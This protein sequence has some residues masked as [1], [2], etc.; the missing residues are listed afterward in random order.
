MSLSLLAP[1]ALGL[2]LLV[3]LPLIAHIARQR[4]R[5]RVPFGA[6]LLLRRVIKRLRRRRRVK[7]PLLLILRI[8]LV[9]M[10]VLA[11]AG[12]RFS[13][14]GGAYDV[15]GT[16]RV[17]LLLDRS[18]SMS[19]QD[20]DSTLLSRARAAALSE[21]GSLPP[22]T[23]IGAVAFDDEAVSLTDGLVSD[24][25]LL[26]GRI[27]ALQ[28]STG[29]SNLRMGLLEARRLLEGEP[30]EVLLFSDE[31]GPT[32]VGEAQEE[33]R[34]L[35][36][37]DSS[38]KPRRQEARVQGNV[39]VTAAE[40][41]EGIEGGSVQVR[42]TN[43]GP[44]P[45]EIPC[46]VRLPDGQVIPIFADLPAHGEVLER[47][48][49]PREALGGVGEARCEDP[50]L[51]ADDVR[52]F[53]LPRV[54]AS[55]VLVVDGDPGDTP[56]RSEVYFLERALAPWGG[57]RSGVTPDV[58]TPLGL[59]EL[60]PEQHQVVFLAN[61]G[62]PR[63]VAPK[64]AE[65]VRKGGAV[66]ISMGGNVSAERYNAAL[67]GLLPA[68][69][70]KPEDLA[71]RGEPGVPIQPPGTDVELFEPFARSGRSGFAE[72]RSRRVMLLDPY[73]ETSDV[74]TLLRYQG[75]VPALVERQVGQGR[76]LLWTSSVDYDWSSLPTQAVF[77]PLVQRIVGYLGAET[78]SGGARLEGVV[79]RPVQF[80]LPDLAIQPEVVGP[81]EQPVRSRIEGS[82]LF[83]TP[84][85]PGAYRLVVES[86]PTLAWVA[87]NLDP[88]ESDVRVYDNTVEEVQTSIV[89]DLFLKH[90]DLSPWLF[91]V[92][93]ALGLLQAL[94]GLSGRST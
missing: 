39:A 89:P 22:G 54:G 38:I 1:L 42:V 84:E 53:H 50:L 4:P 5:E 79:G 93:L 77:M 14:A 91:G 86:A 19:L 90:V 32:M 9:A 13:Y 7:D 49:V 88:A 24:P 51:P 94:L 73:A 74:H 10:L 26:R 25:E 62:D 43:F 15:G 8:L 21:L 92:A 36:E 40:Y 31:A 28:P 69:L 37:L 6:M 44:E 58:V 64:L 47:I 55:R 52:Y 57:V 30:G 3:A 61:V 85:E 67:G 18:M 29:G 70:K 2:G 45:V 78:G 80:E 35:V 23:L 34:R 63:T 76:V 11:I 16:G 46:E 75:G 71:A 59:L 60:D 72:V 65:F 20:G 87:V 48:T 33:I 66:V 82:R 81:D 41:G 27:E 83:F 68:P 17:I 56:I 12:L